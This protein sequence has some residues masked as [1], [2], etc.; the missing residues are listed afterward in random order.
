MV[1]QMFD[2]TA[3]PE[4]KK[5]LLGRI[6]NYVR[7]PQCNFEGPLATPIVYHDNEKELLLTYFPSELG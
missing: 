4:S 2:V 6:S 3:D 7:C 5:R 1:E